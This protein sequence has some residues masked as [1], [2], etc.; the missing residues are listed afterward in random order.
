MPKYA[1]NSK[2]HDSWKVPEDMDYPRL[3]TYL[4]KLIE[5]LGT[6]TMKESH[7]QKRAFRTHRSRRE[8]RQ[9]ETPPPGFF[10][11]VSK[12]NT[13]EIGGIGRQR[14]M[15]HRHRKK[16]AVKAIMKECFSRLAPRRVDVCC[17]SN[18]ERDE[19]PAVG[20]VPR[21]HRGFAP[22]NTTRRHDAGTRLSG[23]TALRA[24]RNVP[25]PISWHNQ[26]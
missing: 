25:T 1:G 2:E 12:I 18:D 10:G 9:P 6:T 16:K 15:K 26:P 22:S 24:A 20:G 14:K 8:Q 5:G 21:C 19:S 23:C 13:K 7:L 4:E 17:P 11:L 3:L